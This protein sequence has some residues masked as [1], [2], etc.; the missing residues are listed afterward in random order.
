MNAEDR[1]LAKAVAELTYCNPFLPERVEFE[2]RALGD[3]FTPHGQVWHFA[4]EDENPNVVRIDERLQ[5]VLE[6][7]R[8]DILRSRVTDADRRLYRDVVFYALYYR[9]QERLRQLAV[10]DTPDQ[11]RR[12]TFYEKFAAEASKY[13]LDP[14]LRLK[15]Q[16]PPELAFAWF[17]QV[18]RAFQFIHHSIIGGSMAAANLRAA[19]W[20]SVFTRDVRRFRRTLYE[21]MGDFTTLITGPSGTGKE[22]VARAIGLSRFI[23]FDP[24]RG[25]FTE[26]FREAFYALN[27]SALSPTLIESELF[28]HQKGAFTGALVDR[29]GWFEE[30]PPLGAV[31][32]DE[33]GE[34]DESIQVKLLRVLQTRTFQRLGDTA[35]RHFRGKLLAATNRDPQ[36]EM[37]AG[38]MRADFYYRL[39]SDLINT[40]SL[41]EQLRESDDELESL[42]LS[43]TANIV[44]LEEAESVAAE[45]L[46]WVARELGTDYDWPGNFRE[47]EQCVRN[48]IVR[49]RY[50]RPG[51]KDAADEHLERVKRGAMTAEELLN[52]YTT[53]VYRK[54]GS[55]LA[56]SR[57]LGLDRRTVKAR[58][59]QSLLEELPP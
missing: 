31:F 25:E 5:P 2:K 36:E 22:L 28:G 4:S 57:V 10:G 37:Q 54:E 18:R 47:L 20:Q 15:E 46:D 7:M 59:D 53:L 43:V 12:A 39:C 23:P 49:G 3:D 21:S 17:F 38:R 26:D 50:L 19:I 56:A 32:L 55:Y 40:P 27:L 41:N 29:A 24:I 11:R 35:D 6:Q 34:I 1:R 9:Y 52:W 13:L 30:C 8:D 48:V 58:V 42:V 45:V 14:D 33:I 51:R 44:G 16:V